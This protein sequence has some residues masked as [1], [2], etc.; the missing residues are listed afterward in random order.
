MLSVRCATTSCVLFPLLQTE[1]AIGTAH[2]DKTFLAQF[3]NQNVDLTQAMERIRIAE[4]EKA[5]NEQQAMAAL[6]EAARLMAEA[7]DRQRIA[8]EA[9]ASAERELALAQERIRASA[10]NV[11]L[12]KVCCFV[13]LLAN[14]AL[15]DLRVRSNVARR[16]SLLVHKHSM[17]CIIACDHVLQEA[18]AG[19]ARCAAEVEARMAARKKAEE[20]ASL[21]AARLAALE[22][23][24]A[25]AALKVAEVRH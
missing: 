10:H 18:E 14:H 11:Q 15:T 19:K 23:A 17:S 8:Q 6:Q 13:Y 12:Q 21:Q 5:S 16:A 4:Q 1:R 25:E 2:V 3:D 24:E 7:N 20:E 22:K 9:A